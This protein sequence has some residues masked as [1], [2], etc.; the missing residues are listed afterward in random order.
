MTYEIVEVESQTEDDEPTWDALDWSYMVMNGDDIIC[1]CATRREAEH[2]V[3]LLNE[4][5][6]DATDTTGK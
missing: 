5:P 4:R 3:D 6:Y 2:I 1:I